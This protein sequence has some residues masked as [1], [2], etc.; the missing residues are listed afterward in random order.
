AAAAIEAACAGPRFDAASI[1]ARGAAG[2][3]PVIPLVRDLGGAVPEAARP[4]V[5]HGATSQD[6]LDTAL[7]LVA[8][9]ALAPVLAAAGRAGD[10][11]A[12]LAGA[13]RDTV[14]VGRTLGQQAAPTTFGLVAAGWLHGLD[15]ST[16]ALGV[17]RDR[18]AAQLGGPVGTLAALGP[19]GPDVLAGFATELGLAA[20]V[21][22]WHTDRQRLL[23]LAAALGR[24]AAAAGKIAVDVVGLAQTE[25]AEL[26]EGGAGRGGSSAMPHKANPVRAVLVA[27][28]A[29]RVPALVSA[30]FSA[31][32]HEHQR[33]AGGWHAE[34]ETLPELVGAVGGAV[35]HTADLLV[36][37]R[38]DTARMRRNL[39]ASGGFAMTERLATAL[40]GVLGRSA[41]HDVVARC[42][43]DAVGRGVPLRT[44]LLADAEVAAAMP[45]ERIDHVLDPS[46]WLGSAD[47]FVTAALAHHARRGQEG[48]R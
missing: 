10:A 32:T 31:G 46:G 1:G 30:M 23:D 33:A 9:R 34:W 39:D 25:V 2:G 14:M 43:R 48:D 40:A 29:R 36:G 7:S 19:T 18:L 17:A 22:P 37:L 47:A 11:A 26:A 6:I 41:A 45:T 28:A 42:C 13:H 15:V 16:A 27:S 24:V 4:W 12:G 35:A 3:N 44:A 20:P 21:L 5:H 8:R 38:V